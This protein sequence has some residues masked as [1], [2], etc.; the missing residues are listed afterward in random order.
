MSTG[1]RIRRRIVLGVV[2][3]GSVGLVAMAMVGTG[4]AARVSSL[5]VVNVSTKQTIKDMLNGRFVEVVTCRRSCSTTTVALVPARAVQ[6][7]LTGAAADKLVVIATASARLR[8]NRAT[9]VTLRPSKVGR[10]ALPRIGS[11]EVIGRVNGVSR[12]SASDTGS[13]TWHFIMKRR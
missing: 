11:V 2:L 1:Y 10:T 6:P 7:N 9:K 3:L 13:A 8:A 12:T 5:L 4:A